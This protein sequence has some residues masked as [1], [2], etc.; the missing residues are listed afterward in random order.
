M[1]LAFYVAL[2]SFFPDSY[3]SIGSYLALLIEPMEKFIGRDRPFI[4]IPIAY[5]V[6]VIM[7]GWPQV[8]FALI[9]GFL[10]RKYRITITPR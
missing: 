9:G 10:S 8:A 4:L 2:V 3:E 7:L 6:A 1:A 5:F